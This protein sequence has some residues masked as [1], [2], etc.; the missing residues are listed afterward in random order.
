MGPHLTDMLFQ[1]ETVEEE[2]TLSKGTVAVTTHRV[3]ALTPEGDGRQLAHADLPNVQDIDIRTKGDA[4][5]LEWA[6]RSGVVGIL[7]LGGGVLLRGND[8]FQTLTQADVSDNPAVAGVGGLIS[9]V[10]TWLSL[11][12]ILLLFAGLLV[13]VATIGLVG[14]YVNTRERELVIEVAERD[15]I[16]IAIDGEEG[17]YAISRLKGAL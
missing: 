6:V 15:P 4:R 11:L 9:M 8:M 14:L 7:M 5:Y 1:G 3:M 10:A 17:N 2:I 16:R 13:L 12:N